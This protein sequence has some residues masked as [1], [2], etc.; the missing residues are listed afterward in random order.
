M[1]RLSESDY[2]QVLDVLYEA[3][4]VEG[5]IPFPDPVLKALRQLVP[6]DVVSYHERLGGR[7]TV[8]FAGEPRGPMTPEIRDATRRTWNKCP[9]TPV[10]NAR[11]Y[12]DVLTPRA[13]HRLELYQECARPL[14]VE[15]MFRL[16]LDPRGE[17]GARLEFDRAQRDFSERDRAVLD[18]LRPHL[19][20]FRRRA[21]RR[22]AHR[23][24]S[25][26]AAR[27]TAREREVVEL[28]AEGM[29]NAEVAR[30]LWLA[31]GT[32]RKHLENAYE[33]LEV[34]TRTAAVAAAFGSFRSDAP[35]KQAPSGIFA[36]PEY[37]FA[38]SGLAQ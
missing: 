26:V 27:L 38:D 10:A 15:D 2:R 24:M 18:E 17:A 13:F 34:H 23:R 25:R 5:P 22:C 16:W 1:A 7:A 11:K 33:K 14:G 9:L 21:N 28:V 35:A 29:T 3:A 19:E 32:V 8:V 20:Q 37:A 31:P 36:G 4:A 12:S 30:V 6:C